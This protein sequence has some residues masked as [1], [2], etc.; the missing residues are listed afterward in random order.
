MDYGFHKE[1]HCG[2]IL[3]E[4]YDDS[5]II[6]AIAAIEA[7]SRVHKDTKIVYLISDN[8]RLIDSMQKNELTESKDRSKSPTAQKCELKYRELK[9]IETKFEKFLWKWIKGHKVKDKTTE[10][11]DYDKFGNEIS[12]R[13]AQIGKRGCII[14]W[15]K[16]E[17]EELEQ[18]YVLNFNEDGKKKK[19]LLENAYLIED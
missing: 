19:Q 8:K 9:K 10:E 5:N 4:N 17:I 14:E 6:E 16:K 3:D 15:L 1:K 18:T 2:S 7:L 11:N 12:D 13:L